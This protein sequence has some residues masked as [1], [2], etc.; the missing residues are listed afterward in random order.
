MIETLFGKEED[1]IFEIPKQ[2]KLF[3]PCRVKAHRDCARQTQ[4]YQCDCTCHVTGG[5]HEAED[6]QEEAED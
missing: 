1:P 5:H 3:E 2:W 6:T 4:V